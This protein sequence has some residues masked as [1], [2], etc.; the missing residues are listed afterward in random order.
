MGNAISRTDAGFGPLL[1]GHSDFTLTFEESIFTTAPSAIVIIATIAKVLGVVGKPTIVRPGALLGLKFVLGLTLAAAHLATLVLWIYLLPVQTEM[2][3]PAAGLAFSGS[4]AVVLFLVVEHIYSYRLSTFMSVFLS[5]TLLLDIAKTYSCFHRTGL[6]AACAMYILSCTSRLLLLAYQEISK[7]HLIYDDEL[8][9]TVN[10]ESAIGFWN[11]SLFLWVNSTLFL[12]FKQILRVEDLPLLAPEFRAKTLFEAFKPQWDR[13]DKQSNYALPFLLLRTT[14]AVGEEDLPDGT[15]GGL[16]GAAALI[17][18]GIAIT[19]GYSTHLAYQVT[20]CLRGTLTVAI[21]DKMLRLDYA[22]LAK[23][24]TVTLMSTDVTGIEG[25]TRLFHDMW[26]AVIELAVGLAILGHIVG[27]SCVLFLIPVTAVGSTIVTKMMIPARAS[28]NEK[29]EDR[30][31]KTSNIIAQLKAIKMAGLSE[32]ILGFIDRLRITEIKT[33]MRE[34]NLRVVIG[35]LGTNGKRLSGGQRQRVALAR[36]VYC[37]APF[38]ILDDPL[39]AVDVTTSE[40]IMQQLLG[41]NGILRTRKTTVVM[42]TSSRDLCSVADSVFT[43]TTEGQ[44]QHLPGFGRGS[45]SRNNKAQQREVTH[46][47]AEKEPKDT[48]TSVKSAPDILTPVSPTRN[49]EAENVVDVRKGDHTLYAYYL[50]SVKKSLLALSLCF[51]ATS[52][53][54]DRLPANKDIMFT[55]LMKEVAVTVLLEIGVI[56]AGARYVSAT[57]PALLII[58]SLVQY[59]YLRTSRQLRVRELEARSPLFTK[60]TETANGIL[61]IRAFK[62]Q[63]NFRRHMKLDG[64]AHQVLNNVSF[65]IGHG[66]KLGISGR[67]GSGK[68]S[69]LAVLLRMI[70]YTGSVFVDGRE[71]RTLPRELLRSRIITLTQDGI[72]LPGTIRFNLDPYNPPDSGSPGLPDE[73]L[74]SA[75]N[76]VGLWETVR[77]CGGLD[78]DMAANFS[79]GQRQLLGIARI[80]VRQSYTQSRIV[81]LDEVT[82]SIDSDADRSIQDVIGDVFADHTVVTVSHRVHAFEKMHKVIMLSDGSIEDVLERDPTSGLLAEA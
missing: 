77:N 16:V 79:V 11:R 44:I 10:G 41:E 34:R 33:S 13:V 4:V 69:I 81:L 65:S 24:A 75:L 64:S 5:I 30:V 53:V 66:E 19:K 76:R 47:D 28:W 60:F 49:T 2:T 74:I 31:A 70:D 67:T 26:A 68:S 58:V 73:T 59:F 78:V 9:S 35:A 62:W 22:T 20:T 82:G 80:I 12:G 54:A 29:I 27:T 3:F 36:A 72:R 37:E 32:P 7:R 50:N 25:L 39:S 57:I 45:D 23:S 21:Y 63:D 8:R 40:F 6:G 18:F 51:I 38:V 71:L 56:C 1:A 52:S 43:I 15:A 17:Y 42:T 48:V 55:W 14:S 46:Q 61:H